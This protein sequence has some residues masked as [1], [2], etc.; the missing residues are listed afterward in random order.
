[1][2]PMPRKRTVQEAIEQETPK[3][4]RVSE[5]ITY[6]LAS[7]PGLPNELQITLAEYLYNAPGANNEF[8]LLNAATNIR[9]LFSLNKR[10][11]ELL[12]DV[13]LAGKIIQALAQRYTN[14]DLVNAAITFNTN[15][16]SIWLAQQIE[17]QLVGSDG[18][19]V[20]ET[21]LQADAL[22]LYNDLQRAL[23]FAV[24][25]NRFDILRFLLTYQ[26]ILANWQVNTIINNVEDRLPLLEV[27]LYR[28]N[29][30]MVRILLTAGAKITNAIV[31]SAAANDTPFALQQLRAA[32][33]N[34]NA[35]YDGESLFHFANNEQVIAYLVAQ[36]ADI[37]VENNKGLTALQ[38]ALYKSQ[39]TIAN[40]LLAYGADPN[41][42]NEFGDTALHSAL[43][44]KAPR[45][46]IAMIVNKITNLEVTN[47]D[48]N[49]PLALAILGYDRAT[50]ELLLS[51]GA[52]LPPV[53][54]ESG[55][56]GNVSAISPL[57]F[58]LRMAG[59]T[60]PR[61]LIK[62]VELLL[63]HGANPN[64]M[65]ADPNTGTQTTLL[66]RMKNDRFSWT[67]VFHNII[68]MLKAF[69]GHE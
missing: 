24:N 25:N 40:L 49:T 9:N 64:E 38:D 45:E 50:I 62:I 55:T 8:K 41:I 6:P 51:R 3:A 52:Q 34:L 35:R 19:I 31:A 46:T 14:N 28:E 32:G 67:S 42:Q 58:I 26:P 39:F 17:Q 22:R 33:V 69:G 23:D 68:A 11:K 60:D 30:E 47:A 5:E 37:N 7:L 4:Q 2:E 61:E 66:S 63:A 54:Y 15:A 21:T 44:K 16:A 18:T 29:A 27:A 10:Y 1:M 12:D 56:H 36:G 57:V 53:I 59:E 48:G 65:I 20:P 13:D 43:I